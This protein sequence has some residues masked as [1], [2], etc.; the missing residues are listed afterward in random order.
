[1]KTKLKVISSKIRKS[2]RKLMPR[3]CR[4]FSPTPSRLHFPKRGFNWLQLPYVFPSG[5]ADNGPKAR[6]AISH[7]IG[8]GPW[9]VKAT[10]VSLLSWTTCRCV[11]Y[12]RSA[13]RTL[14]ASW[15][16][17]DQLVGQRFVGVSTKPSRVRFHGAESLSRNATLAKGDL[18]P[19]PTA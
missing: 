19:T 12:G 8:N 3:P 18:V 15:L 13:N 17:L 4:A 6:Q 16:R 14:P 11:R 10:S 1:M 2:V 7:A 9:H 5:R